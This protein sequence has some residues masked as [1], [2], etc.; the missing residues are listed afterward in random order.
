MAEFGYHTIGGISA[1][2]FNDDVVYAG[3]R[4]AATATGIVTSIFLY[5][6]CATAGQDMKFG[7]YTDSGNSPNTKIGTET[8]FVN[9][10]TWSAEWHEFGGLNYSVSNGVYYW[11]A[12][13]LVNDM[14]IYYASVGET[15]YYYQGASGYGNSWPS[16]FITTDDPSI[17]LSMYAIITVAGGVAPT[18]TLFGP[19]GGPLRGVL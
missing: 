10:G 6:D 17:T 16:P 8:E 15:E 13:S 2:D 4:A 12:V 5:C 3:V 1:P 7:I 11:L 9:V 18:G 14:T 19:F